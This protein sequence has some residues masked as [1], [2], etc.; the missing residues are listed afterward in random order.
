MRLP[1]DRYTAFMGSLS[2]PVR[3]LM[4]AG[5]LLL[6]WLASVVPASAAPGGRPGAIGPVCELQTITLKKL[7]RL[8]RSFGGPLKQTPAR[9]L[10]F[11]LTDPT[12]RVRRG[13]HTSFHGQQAAI[14]NDAPAARI[15]ESAGSL[16]T[17]RPLENLVRP[18][19]ARPRSPTCSP[20]PPRGP[21]Q[22]A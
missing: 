6:L 14:Q 20:R 8:H 17:L 22:A 4:T 9:Q 5:S 13:T 19:D 1:L 3:T 16:P 2:S 12:A 11:G 7:T 10:A 15:D 21:P 18:V